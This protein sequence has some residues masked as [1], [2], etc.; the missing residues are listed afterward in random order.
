MKTLY[1]G[2]IYDFSIIDLTQ[3]KGYKDFGKGFY[4]TSVKSHADSI[5]KR[6]KNFEINKYKSVKGRKPVVVAYR[7]NLDYDDSNLGNLNVKVFK[8]ANIEWVR[9]ILMNRGCSFTRHNY[10]IVI[11]PTADENTVSILNN[12]KNDLLRTN[13]AESV[14]QSLIRDLEP[15]N[16]PKQYFFGTERSLIT[17]KF[18]RIRREII[19]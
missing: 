8:E 5:A 19:G 9:F 7:Y 11:G 12:Y 3:G 10:D 13:Y 6:N 17:L 14:L 4:A 1:H 15:E 16:L 18:H 2:S